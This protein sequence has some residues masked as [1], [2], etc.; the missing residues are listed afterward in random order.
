M[1]YRV[2]VVISDV[3]ENNE[4]ITYADLQL[5]DYFEHGVDASDF[6]LRVQRV[7]KE[8]QQ[9]HDDGIRMKGKQNARRSSYWSE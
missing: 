6:A 8:L 7:A 5:A 4:R 1:G 3:N 2:S 9:H